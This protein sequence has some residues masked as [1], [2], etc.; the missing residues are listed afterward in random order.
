MAHGQL[1]TVVL[2]P[3]WYEF[4]MYEGGLE[5][6]VAKSV[7]PRSLFRLSHVHGVWVAYGALQIST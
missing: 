1:L 4:V 7:M 5:Q 6:T 3:C 2:L